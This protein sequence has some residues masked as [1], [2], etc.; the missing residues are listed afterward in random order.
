MS[1]RRVGVLLVK[2]LLQGSKSFILVWA[3]VAPIIISFVISLIFGTWFTEK[4]KLGIYDE[5]G[6]E[7]VMASK[8]LNSVITREYSTIHEMKAAVERGTVDIGMALP[9]GFDS[10]L[11]EGEE[12]EI[13]AYVWGES[14]AK[15]RIIL[16]TT[17]SNLIRDLVGQ[18]TPVEIESI[19]LGTE[20]SVSWNNRLLPLIVLMAVFLGGV[21]LPATSV[22]NEKEKG[23]LEA[24]VV[25]PTSIADIFVAKGLVG[26]IL[27]L[28]MGVL[29]LLINRAF[30]TEPILLLLVLA[31]GAIMAS[32]LG[33]L[34]GTIVKS[35]TM[36]FAIWKFG[37]GLLLFGPAIVYMFPDIPQW[38]GKVFPTYYLI[39]PIVELSKGSSSW[40]NI[41]LSVF[42]LAGLDLLLIGIVMILLKRKRQFAV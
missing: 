36:L 26:I 42:I 11:I 5:D 14:L 12:T 40:S 21:M 7:L 32:G 3:V 39:Q 22:I 23:T 13:T 15:N 34:L 37:G 10:S 19:T 25:T 6:S 4:P 1:L 2:E 38:I 33:L 17:I 16:A 8:E 29:I 9:E 24:V 18:E 28:F 31:L 20:I 41:A 30:G 27:S 35:I